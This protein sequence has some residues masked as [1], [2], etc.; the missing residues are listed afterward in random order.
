MQCAPALKKYEKGRI[1]V[2]KITKKIVAFCMAAGMLM[3][4]AC[5]V[6]DVVLPENTPGVAE[7]SV[8]EPDAVPTPVMPQKT[9]TQLEVEDNPWEIKPREGCE[10]PMYTHWA[11]DVGGR[12][13]TEETAPESIKTM[14]P[15]VEQILN[16][17]T[18]YDSYYKDLQFFENMWDTN[19]HTMENELYVWGLMA[20]VLCIYGN[21]HPNAEMKKGE[22]FLSLPDIQDFI[23]VC[24]VDF[25]AETT[26]PETPPKEWL[27]NP[28]GLHAEPIEA[29]KSDEECYIFKKSTYPIA[30]NMPSRHIIM[31]AQHWNESR[32]ELDFILLF[33]PD[34]YDIAVYRV[35]L[36]ANETPDV[37]GLEW[38][39]AQIIRIDTSEIKE[40]EYENES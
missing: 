5:S 22:I 32:Y 12:Y 1:M 19:Q 10:P 20:N 25:P 29:V 9:E 2:Q 24:F 34:C 6:C 8:P 3:L 14:L 28:I 17:R 33:G 40:C 4:C 7:T 39:V 35:A 18:E 31:R 26:F 37:F 30:I 15:L 36:E 23:S 21:L 11:T 13:D 16:F 27:N 38:R